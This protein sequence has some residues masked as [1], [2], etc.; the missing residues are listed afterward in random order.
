FLTKLSKEYDDTVSFKVEYKYLPTDKLLQEEP[1]KRIDIHVKATGFKLISA[2]LFP[3]KINVDA[4]NLN[5]KTGTNYFVL[6]SQQ[7]LAIQRQMKTGVEIDHFITDSISFNLGLLKK[8]K[9]PVRVNSNLTYNL[10]YDMD[11]TLK[12]S[13]DSIFIS[14]PESVLDTINYVVTNEF[15]KKGVHK[16]INEEL[17]IK[18]FPVKSNIKLQQTRVVVS[19][20]VEKFT[21][22]TIELPFRLTN[23]PDGV[24]ISTYPKLVMVTYR[25]ALSNFNKINESSFVLECDYKMSLDNNLT[26]LVPK[27][28]KKSNLVKNTKISPT[29]IDFITEK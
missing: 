28:I 14:G 24:S 20:R 22:G 29:K 8:K 27:L 13:P 4:S 21:E 25:V 5:V 12:I 11:G 17:I 10:G 16:S 26:Y 1:A 9:I 2:G 15:I 3:P 23:L 18:K 7:R 6:L 19:A